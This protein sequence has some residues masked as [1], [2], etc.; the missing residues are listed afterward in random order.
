MDRV[1]KVASKEDIF[2]EYQETPIGRLLEYHNLQR[3]YEVYSH[4]QLLIGMCMDYRKTLHIPEN[5]AYILR[6]GGGNLRYSEFNVS[7]CIAMGGVKAIALIAHNDCGMEGL[8]VKKEQFVNGLVENAGW[9]RDFAE[10]HF[11]NFASMFEIGNDIDFVISEAARLRG[12][13]PKI[14]VAPLYFNVENNE[15]FLLKE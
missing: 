9:D 5:F 1:V 13:Y 14:L 6:S 10:A 2:P 4:A 12:R 11:T 7:Y 15:L 3:S 8:Q